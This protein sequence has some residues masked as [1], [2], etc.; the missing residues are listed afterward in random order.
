MLHTLQNWSHEDVSFYQCSRM[1]QD[2]LLTM[3][4]VS[5][6]LSIP[7]HIFY[8][9]FNLCFIAF[10]LPLDCLNYSFG[11][12]CFISSVLFEVSLCSHSTTKKE[13]CGCGKEQ[14][15]GVRC[16]HLDCNARTF[17]LE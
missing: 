3:I 4:K 16:T 13:G 6:F 7:Y 10:C 17:S 15:G 5:F 2:L 11:Y 8:I 14:T 9:I 1:R 12:S